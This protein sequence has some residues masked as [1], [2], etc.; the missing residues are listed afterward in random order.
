[1]NPYYQRHIISLKDFSREDILFLLH[2]TKHMKENPLSGQLQGKILASCFFEP[3]TRTRLSFES[4]MNRLGG[5]VIGFS[6]G[7]T[8][9]A[10]K[11]ESLQDSIKILS[12]YAD[13]LILRHAYEGAAQLAAETANIPVI[14]AGDGANQHPTQTFLDLFTIMECQGKLDNL[15][16]AM[17]GDLKYGRTVH[18]LAQGLIPFKPRLYFMSPPGLE[19]PKEICNDLKEMGIKFSFHKGFDEVVPKIDI[20]YMTRIQE[21]RFA[22]KLEFELA[23]NTFILK[24]DYL[25]DVKPNLKI[26]HPLPRILEIDK[27]LDNSPH[28]HYFQQAQNG[29]WVR[30]ALLTLILSQPTIKSVL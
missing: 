21:E 10:A 18:S 17:A 4:A 9:S 12:H 23:K 1:M 16:I 14:N 20:L 6:E 13:V 3:S 22:H 29:L 26:L 24:P 7:L 19:M 8:T 5:S 27:S 30:Q 25:K 11:G 2:F 28:A 15:H